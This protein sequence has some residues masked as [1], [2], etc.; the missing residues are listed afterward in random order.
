MLKPVQQERAAH[1]ARALETI[2]VLGPTIQ[3]LTPLSGRDSTPCIMRSTIPPGGF[4]PL[5]AHRDIETFIVVS[6]EIEGLAEAGDG[7]RWL[8]LRPG[9][10]FHV[11]GGARH[12]FR[13]RTQEPCVA[14]IVTTA[15]MGRFFRDIGMPVVL[16]APAGPPLAEAVRQFQ[17]VSERYGFWN[18][19]AEDNARVGLPVMA[20]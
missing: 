14:V 2:D 17:E 7:F 19:P 9:D 12:A 15:T 5:H 20:S 13:N 18:A 6:G 16:G 3:F 1:L 8:T 10:V 4:V 11:P